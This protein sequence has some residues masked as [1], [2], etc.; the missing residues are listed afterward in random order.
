MKH[1]L[2]IL[3]FMLMCQ[4]SFAQSKDIRTTNTYHK[5]NNALKTKAEYYYD[6]W[7]EQE[8]YHGRFAEWNSQGKLIYEAK[9]VD[10]KLIGKAIHYHPNGQIAKIENWFNGKREGK[11]EEFY[12]NG[13]L[14]QS[15][16]YLDDLLDGELQLYSKKGELKKV[17][18][19]SKGRKQND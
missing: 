18:V 7:S 16:T 19:Y 8:V 12:F 9:Y 4:M 2:F 11:S 15:C 10:G 17:V 14:K 6:S 1:T 5:S 13:Q 3:T